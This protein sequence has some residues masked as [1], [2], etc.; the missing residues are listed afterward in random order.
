MGS[1]TA[2]SDTS[3]DLERIKE[4]FQL[5][6]WADFVRAGDRLRLAS[7]EPIASSGQSVDPPTGFSSQ[8]TVTDR[9]ESETTVEGDGISTAASGLSHQLSASHGTDGPSQFSDMW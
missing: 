6:T 8:Q 3:M 7:S 2:T 1:L 9:Q 5:Y 4:V